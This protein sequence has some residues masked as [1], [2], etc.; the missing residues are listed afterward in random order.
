MGLELKCAACG[1]NTPVEAFDP[2]HP[3]V[4]AKCSAALPAPEAPAE[5]A[6]V[7]TAAA[8][9]RNLFGPAGGDGKPRCVLLGPLGI[10]ALGP[11]YKAYDREA[12]KPFGV[13]FMPGQAGE[14]QGSLLDREIQ[15]LVALPHPNILHVQGT[16]RRQNR[17][18]IAS[19][20]VEAEPLSKSKIQEIPR[21]CAIFRDAAEAVDYAHGA[22][23]LHGDLNPE[24]ILV[25][26]ADDHVF[27]K[28][29]QLAHLMETIARQT[30]AK[31]AAVELH[32][33]AYLSP[34]QAATSKRTPSMVGD[35]Y[36]LGATLYAAIAGKPPF[37]GERGAKALLEEAPP[38]EQLRPDVPE[39][40]GFIV[41]R[42]MAKEPE[43]RHPSAKQLAGALTK[44]LK[45]AA[46]TAEAAKFDPVPAPVPVPVEAAVPTPVA[47]PAAAPPR[48]ARRSFP[49]PPPP[50]PGRGVPRWAIAASAAVVL[51]GGAVFFAV[52]VLSR[53]SDVAAKP[54]TTSTAAA[55]VEEPGQLELDVQPPPT[56][57]RVD[58]RKIDAAQKTLPLKRGRHLLEFVFGDAHRME[59]GVEIVAG[60]TAKVEIAAHRAIAAKHE[61]RG[62]WADAERVCQEALARPVSAEER[63]ELQELVARVTQKRVEAESVLRVES[64]PPGATV[65]VDGK[66]SGRTPL[67][68][69]RLQAGVRVI[70]LQHEGYVPETRKVEYQPGKTPP[71][72]V[73]LRPRTGRIRLAGLKAGDH[74]RLGE[75]IEEAKADGPLELD[76]VNV[77]EHEIVVERKGYDDLKMKVKVD[78]ERTAQAPA[79]VFKI[80]PGS[81]VV[82]SIPPGAEVQL[83]GRVVGRTPMKLSD[84][85]PG[86]MKLRILH[87]D[88][89]DFESEVQ[90]RGGAKTDV[91]ATLA[92]LAK[93]TVITHPEGAKLSGALSGVTRAEGRLKA[94]EHKVRVVH[95]EAGDA[96][97]VY[98]L[99]AG[100]EVSDSVDLWEIRGEEYEK[101][102]KLEDAGRAY[103]RAQT[104][105]QEKGLLRLSGAW[106]RRAEDFIKTRDWTKARQAAAQGVRLAPSNAWAKEIAA[107]ITY[108]EA[109]LQADEWVAK[110]DWIRA[111]DAT[112]RALVARPAD[113]RAM[114]LSTSL[115]YREAMM[116]AT[117]MQK[118]ARWEDARRA[119]EAALVARPGDAEAAGALGRLKSLAW[120]ELRYFPGYA[121]SVALDPAGKI[122]AAG[123]LDKTVQ[124]WS[125]ETGMTIKTLSG[126]SGPVS[127]LAFSPDGKLL[128][129][130]AADNTVK[131]WEVATGAE[132]ET[133]KGHSGQVG[134][135]A[136]APDG[137]RL[138]SASDDRTIRLWESGTWKELKILSGHQN[139]VASVAFSPDGRWLVSAGGDK[140]IRIW[141]AEKGE[142]KRAIAGH[143]GG[144]SQVAFAPDGKR[145]VS[146]SVDQK[147][148]LWDF[149]SGSELRTCSGHSAHV[150]QAS[151]TTDGRILISGSGDKSIRLWDVE[152]G[153]ELRVLPAR[154]GEVW[155]IALS[156]DGSRMASASSD[157]TRLWGLGK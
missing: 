55:P 35:V 143:E 94:G 45:G 90:I 49:P 32:N 130:G 11:V 77:G 109:M 63:R 140:S 111:R 29:F 70:E 127:S 87:P 91:N 42:A 78:A 41:R 134:G 98:K 138:A 2:A 34:E 27:V 89:S 103:L 12:R 150:A 23:I 21:L 123:R 54:T 52:R 85:A 57:V 15:K 72:R 144:V 58:G 139:S 3:P 62:R 80:T 16:G 114:E 44:F 132:L 146:A 135:V 73:E 81:L 59:R 152:T 157:G 18:Y 141:D 142:E 51:L 119:Y 7:A 20:L 1:E 151:F 108:E 60:E 148:K 129:S 122:L 124:L 93:L 100:D 43:V 147:I 106:V 154:T 64:E 113:P 46:L 39:G 75:R 47:A 25:G 133:L 101:A 126:H 104:R 79:L 74:V 26:G 36:G 65:N 112:A 120:S 88:R 156:V 61:E 13:R 53:P 4:C 31:D 68:L 121:F 96:E 10:D 14:E 24:N 115:A 67:D 22:G 71:L 66:A 118:D 8:N 48:T 107:A 97:R 17:A 33:S 82:E 38:L 92:M 84:L 69:P 19:D 136:F 40:L 50:P 6:D 102:G 145:L 153:R 131:V 28:D 116:R 76:A 9:E 56:E 99:A 128:A 125:V 30:A 37:E 105:A 5:P 117:A 95:A 149:E 86:T 110:N 83:D 155:S 137:K